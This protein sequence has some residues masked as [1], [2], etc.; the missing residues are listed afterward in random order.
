[1]RTRKSKA[2]ES[3]KVEDVSTPSKQYTWLK[4]RKG[5]TTPTQ[6]KLRILFEQ[7]MMLSKY[8]VAQTEQSKFIDEMQETD[9][10][11][12]EHEEERRTKFSGLRND[13]F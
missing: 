4:K 11:N 6:I 8:L 12:A 10:Y 7:V 1:M 2:K 13:N 5:L 9:W 3:S